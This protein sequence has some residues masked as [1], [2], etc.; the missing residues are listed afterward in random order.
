M[1]PFNPHAFNS[2]LSFFPF[3]FARQ[4][5]AGASASLLCPFLDPGSVVIPEYRANALRYF[6]IRADPG[7]FRPSAFLL[8]GNRSFGHPDLVVAEMLQ[9]AD[10]SSRCPQVAFGCIIL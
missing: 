7:R 4:S 1:V 8:V 2:L 5:A 10:R 3:C 6:V 9:S